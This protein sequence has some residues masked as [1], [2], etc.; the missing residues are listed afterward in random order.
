MTVGPSKD[1]AGNDV[2][3]SING[4]ISGTVKDN[5]GKGILGVTVTLLDS[6]GDIV[7]TAT[8][9]TDGGYVFKDVEPGDYTVVKTQPEG[10][11]DSLSD[12]E[13]TPKDPSFC[14]RTTL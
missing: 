10:F 5:N 3:D 11:P 2:V 6:K 14:S 1:D 7:G 12:K 4:S 8:T 9:I 13:N